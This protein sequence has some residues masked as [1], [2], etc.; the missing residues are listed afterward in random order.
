[1]SVY[2][3]KGDKKWKVEIRTVDSTGKAIRKRKSGFNTKKEAVLWEQEFLNKLAS[4]SNI[5]F[6]TMWEIY[7]ED[8]RL[9]VKDSTIIRKIQLMNNYILPIFGNI[10]VNEINTNHIRNFQNELLKK[11]F[12]KIPLE[13]LKAKRNVFLILQ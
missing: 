12:P 7:L 6:K 13:L 2:K 11:T 10:L 1:M 5:T 9:K 8:C 4:N 3:E